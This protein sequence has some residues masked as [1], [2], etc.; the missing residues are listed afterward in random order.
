MR[1]SLFFAVIGLLFAVRAEAQSSPPPAPVSL[2]PGSLAPAAP[3]SPAPASARILT[4]GR[5]S[6]AQAAEH[7]ERALAWYRAGKYRR[8]A[9]ELEAA[10]ERDPGGKDLMFN[11]ALVQEKLGDLAGAIASL[12]RFQSMEKDPKELERASQTIERLRGAQA[13][14]LAAVPH[15]PTPALARVDCPAPRMRG[16]FDGW[17]IGTG[18]LA[19]ASLLVGV[20]F[21]VRA[22]TLD[23]N[24][25]ESQ[26]RD[27]AMVA[28][29]ALATGVLSGAGSFALYWG[30]FADPPP[31]RAALP[32]WPVLSGARGRFQ[33]QF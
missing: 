10:L 23:A 12:Q 11:L 30:R 3:V 26:A 31:E 7:F 9:E 1:S 5:A 24:T 13:E 27:A 17:V 22:L 29:V 6:P 25:E 18:S 20:V 28:D 4:D 16:K 19:L 2:A 21:G 8:A 15:E 14:L 32:A 33:I